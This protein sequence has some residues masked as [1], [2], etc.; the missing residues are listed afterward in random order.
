MHRPFF[1]LALFF[2]CGLAAVPAVSE[3]SASRWWAPAVGAEVN[4]PKVLGFWRFDSE[5]EVGADASSKGATGRLAGAKWHPEG[6][7][8]GGALESAA[9]F[10]VI[11]ERH[12]F[13]VPR[14]AAPAPG[15]AFTLEMWLKAKAA[16]DFPAEVQPVLADSKYVRDNPSG[17]QWGLSRAGGDG[18]RRFSLEIGLGV[19]S[20]RW[21]SETFALPPGEWRHAAF[22]YDG[23]GTVV[24]WLDGKEIG[25]TTKSAAGT[26]ASAIRELSLGDRL[27]SNYHGFPGWI[28]EIRFSEGV[29]EFRPVRL[30]T[31]ATKPAFLRFDE[32]ST[33]RA[34]LRNQSP[35]A[36]EGVEVHLTLP[37]AETKT[38]SVPTL[39]PG[40]SHPLEIPLDSSLRPGEYTLGITAA[41]PGW[42][43]DDVVHETREDLPFVLVPR[44]LPHRMPVVMWGLGGTEAVVKELP[45]LKDLGFTHCFGLRTDVS[46]FWKVDPDKPPLSPEDIRAGRDM[47]DTALANDFG[48]IATVSPGRWLKD[49]EA[50]KPFLRVDREGTP[51]ERADISGLFP[52]VKQFFHRVGVSLGRTWGDHPAFAAALIDTEVRDHTQLSFHPLEVKA[53]RAALGGDIPEAAKTKNGVDHTKLPDFPENRVLPD[54]DPLLAYYRWFW[55]AGDGWNGL[56]S[57]LNEGLRGEMERE[58]FWTFFDPA[59]RTP[60]IGGSGGSVDVLSQWTYTYPDPVRIGL[61]TDELFEMARAGGRDQEVMKMTQIIWYRSQTAPISPP[62]NVETSPWVDQDPDAAYITIAPMHLREALW[63][64][65]A[66][67]VSGIMY[68]GWGSLVET[69]SPSSYVFTNPNTAPELKRLVEEVVEPLGPTLLQVPDPKPEVAFLES[70]TSQMFARRGTYGWGRGWGGDLYQ[71]V[72]RAQLQPRILYEETLLKGGL[73][74][75]EVLVMGDCDVLTESVVAAVLAFQKAGG[76]VVGDEELCPAIQPDVKVPRYRRTNVAADDFAA[77][78][79][80]SGTLRTDLAA[81]GYEWPL[82]S[83]NPDVLT[84]RRAADST[85]YLFAINDKREAGSY[86]GNYG[87]VM[88]NGLPSETILRLRREGGGHVYDLLARRALPA[89]SEDG[90]LVVP[91]SLGPCEGRLLMVSDRP[92][93]Q[94]QLTGPKNARLGESVEIVV[95]VTDADGKPLDAVVPVDLRIVDPEGVPAEPNG[96]YGAAGGVLRVR[97]DLASNDRPGVWEIRATEGATGREIRTYLRVAL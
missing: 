93:E 10:P 25:R 55:T 95:S 5:A 23:R 36:L 90:Q 35:A 68:H 81:A 87:K 13:V 65:L 46:S 42:G 33:V 38:L 52:E 3:E 28:D 48:I 1:A 63:L 29:L 75:V 22:S 89:T 91:L 18:Q 86:V 92:V 27:G 32:T 58:D 16:E 74:G 7:F 21:Y 78:A 9:G 64:K 19:R 41:V 80:L 31:E 12:A 11:D 49:S 79:A 43:G 34:T 6:R 51:Y 8:D 39:A 71:T 20:E 85:D 70:F 59:V 67:P 40:A 73:E 97:L 4:G 84:R 30:D 44:P 15:G 88:E 69:D 77:L 37:G 17:F 14:D 53:A 57:Q 24:F 61:A 60:S 26:M 45:R 50:G 96:V 76:L 83:D 94:I 82:A 56:H 62:E 2:C 47:L 72:V 54:D 66:R